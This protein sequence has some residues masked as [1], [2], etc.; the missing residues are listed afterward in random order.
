MREVRN[1]LLETEKTTIYLV[2]VSLSISMFFGWYFFAYGVLLGAVL[3]IINFR[4]LARRAVFFTKTR[5]KNVY[6]YFFAAYLSRLA[7]I[8]AVFF[9]CLL[10][11]VR[12]F[13]GAAAGF[14]FIY[15]SIFLNNFIFHK[16]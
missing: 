14:L 13:I 12:L 6:V 3:S 9:I 8:G 2:I 10:K 15:I 1:T 5:K 7:V 11:E 16:E 4:L